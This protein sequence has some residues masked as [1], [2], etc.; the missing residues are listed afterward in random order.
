MPSLRHAGGDLAVTA[1]GH[2]PHDPPPQKQLF[3]SVDGPHHRAGGRQAGHR[4]DGALRG[5]A[6]ITG[7]VGG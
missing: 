4:E 5:S 7:L 6:A 3:H 2:D 1:S